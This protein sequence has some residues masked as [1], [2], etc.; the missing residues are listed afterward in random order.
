VSAEKDRPYRAPA[1]LD[2]DNF[3][4][5]YPYTSLWHSHVIL[6]TPSQS[7]NFITLT[8]ISRRLHMQSETVRAKDAQPRSQG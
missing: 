8:S 3:I 1:K 5:T 4:M 6:I 7:K 2:S